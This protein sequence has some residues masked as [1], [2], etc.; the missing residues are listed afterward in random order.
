M[1]KGLIALRQSMTMMVAA[2]VLMVFGCAQASSQLPPTGT[3]SKET[4][5]AIVEKPIPIKPVPLFARVKGPHDSS[6]ILVLLAGGPG[7]PGESMLAF[8]DVAPAN[9]RVIS[10]DQ[11]GV[12]RSPAPPGTALGYAEHVADLEEMRV[13][14]GARRMHLL[15]HSWGGGLALLYAGAHPD[16]VA[17]LMLVANV[18]YIPAAIDAMAKSQ[19]ARIGQLIQEGI[20]KMPSA[21]GPMDCNDRF[22]PILP[23]YFADPR[24]PIP[25]E[26]TDSKINCDIWAAVD[27]ST[28]KLDT[29]SQLAAVKVPTLVLMGD[30][31]LLG[32]DM[33]RA[34]V[35][36]LPASKAELVV[37]PHCG[38]FPWIECP[39]ALFEAV[40]PFLARV[41][42]ESP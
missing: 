13:K 22:R 27:A 4:S 12:G 29:T 2:S 32:L 10:Y 35:A 41:V 28:K 1:R 25:K 36:A 30:S 14:L 20:V 6:D 31:D 23:A 21:S 15:G 18:V 5:P 3:T 16:H 8:E 40:R 24:F 11:R 7:A 39:T 33:A 34:T 19:Q 26:I 9:I 17:S 37:L 42:G 38:H